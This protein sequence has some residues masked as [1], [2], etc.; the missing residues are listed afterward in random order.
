M[1]AETAGPPDA[2]A[3]AHTEPT[4]PEVTGRSPAFA[5]GLWVD[6]IGS[7]RYCG[8]NTRGAQVLVGSAEAG[9]VFTPG[10]LMKIALA[11]CSGMSA[12]AS[13][14]RRLGDDVAISVHVSGPSDPAE[15][16]YPTLHEELVVDLSGLSR[17]D[18]SRVETV[19]RR[20]IDRSCTVGRTL[21]QSAS[22]ELTVSSRDAE[23]S[24]AR[25]AATPGAGATLPVSDAAV[26]A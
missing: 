23:D 11:G 26:R 19:I 9:A 24:A 15:V 10:E 7:R 13:L 18:R 3:D 25:D 22:V 5:D 20:A 12:D 16:R 17:Q 14:A 21:E 8:H 6:R 1:T 4:A 2:R